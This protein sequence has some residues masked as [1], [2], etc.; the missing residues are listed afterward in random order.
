MKVFFKIFLGIIIALYPILIFSLLVIFKLP[1]RIISLCV[2]V[3]AVTFFLCV[4]GKQ[5]NQNKKVDIRPI[6]SSSLFLIAGILCFITQQSIF[7]RLYS[8]VISITM[9]F[10]FGSTLI[11]PPNMIFRFAT[12][13]DKT[14]KGSKFEEKVNQ[15]CKKVTIVWCCFFSLNGTISFLTAFSN[16]IFPNINEDLANTIW[17]VYNGGISY[18]LMGLLFIIEYCIRKKVDKRIRCE[19]E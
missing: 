14:I 10:L 9:L 18:I 17:S 3:L 6:I 2:I 13:S 1:I 16:K 12:L 15:Y 19:E 5:K 11:Y 7:L 8:V 4:T